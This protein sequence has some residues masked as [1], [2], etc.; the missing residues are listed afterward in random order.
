MADEKLKTALKK[1]LSKKKVKLPNKRTINL[2]KVTEPP[3]I[4]IA[5]AI[6]AALLICAAAGLFAKFAVVDRYN[7]L[8]EIQRNNSE[9]SAQI[10]RYKQIIIENEGLDEE[11]A[12]YTYTGMTEE[13]NNRVDRVSAMNLVEKYVFRDTTLESMTVYGN[14]ITL[15]CSGAT[16]DTFRAIVA[17]MEKD[18]AVNFCTV[19]AANTGTTN[20]TAED[21]VKAQIV[22]YLNGALYMTQEG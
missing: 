17:E 2:A 18:P 19:N 14:T 1:D 15:T 8:S 21:Y 3:R 6:P 10:D 13:E 11:Y 9:L 16:L 12:H 5:K 4:N 22:I 7:E 20:V